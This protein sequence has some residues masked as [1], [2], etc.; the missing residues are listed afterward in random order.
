VLVLDG[1]RLVEQGHPAELAMRDSRFSA[2]FHV[3]HAV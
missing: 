3:P 1:S 2:L